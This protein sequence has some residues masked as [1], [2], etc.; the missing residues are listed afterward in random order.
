MKLREKSGH[1]LSLFLG[2]QCTLES[3]SK[4]FI[5]FVL[6]LEVINHFKSQLGLVEVHSSKLAAGSDHDSL[7]GFV[8]SV[9]IDLLHSVKNVQSVSDF[10]KDDMSSVE[11]GSRTEAEEELRTV[12]TWASIGHGKDTTFSVLIGKVLVIEVLAVD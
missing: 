3:K 2:K 7:L 8:V 6:P 10:A 5:Q 9:T 11:M 4:H 12:G 1:N